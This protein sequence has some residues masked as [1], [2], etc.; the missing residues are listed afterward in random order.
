MKILII[1]KSKHQENTLK[2]A[3]AMSEAG[4]VTVTELD[5]VKTIN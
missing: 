1:V 3:E 5:N 2:I 4:P